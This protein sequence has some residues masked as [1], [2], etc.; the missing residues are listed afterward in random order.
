[1]LKSLVTRVLRKAAK[2]QL[3]QFSPIIVA[4]TGSVGKTSTKNA[5]AIALEAKY[6]V[7]K[8]EKNYNNEIGVPL[9]ILGESSPGKDAWEWVKLLKRARK[10]TSFPKYLV[11]EFGADK[12]GDIA[13]LCQ[14][15]EPAVGVITAVSPVH[16]A[17]YPNFAALAEEKATLGDHVPE[18]GLVVINTDDPTVALMTDRFSAP[19]VTY[20]L[21]DANVTASDIRIETR[22]DDSFDPDEVFAITRATVHANGEVAELALKNCL[23]TMPVSAS[24]AAIAVARHAKIPV[25]RAVEALNAQF[26]PAP[27]RMRP[28][29]GIKGSLILDDT[30]NAAPAS[31]MA[32]LD[33][34]A[35]FETVEHKR[36]IVVL[37]TMAELGQYSE[38]E[39]RNIG[40]K[41]AEVA[42]MFIAVGPDM[43]FAADEAERAGLDADAIE[44]LTDSVEA[45][46]YLDCV[47]KKGDIVLIKGS[48]SARMERAVKDIM[49]DPLRAKDFLCRQDGNWLE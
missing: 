21:R 7:R 36:K 46:R 47:I 1:M 26:E 15:A 11:L 49:A 43:K 3:T 6:S 5:I 42:D 2:R 13:A 41:V 14:L 18:H 38:A 37:G 16:A 19:V 44:W 9:A 35:A 10:A 8:A 30:Y 25:I 27:G 33:T 17:N 39:H 40:R 24:L 28:V 12:P 20:G 22:I 31:V 45:G 4:V 29:P 23:G 48:Q 32:A 34:L